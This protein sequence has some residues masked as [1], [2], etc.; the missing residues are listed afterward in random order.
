VRIV[1]ISDTHLTAAGGA[2][3]RNLERIAAFV[4][5]ALRPDLIVHTGDAVAIDPDSAADRAFALAAHAAFDAPVR[6]VPGN[7]DVGEPGPAPREGLAITSARV[8][9]QREAFGADRF[10]EHAG[11]WGQVGVDSRLFG[12]GLPEEAEQWDWLAATLAGAGRHRSGVMPFLHQPLWEPWPRPSE[13]VAPSVPD[14][15]RERLLA[16]DGAERIRAGANGHLHVYRR[17]P[18]R[19]LL[20]VSGP[21]TGFVGDDDPTRFDQLG[22]V[23]W[24]LEAGTASAR[25]RAPADLEERHPGEIPELVAGIDAL[26]RRP[27][28]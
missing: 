14:A 12:S 17:R 7:H 9:A 26:R 4:K 11:G 24:V 15:A 5:R 27:A 22:V 10:A 3:A 28:A 1:Q 13:G 2:P 6:F 18:D 16:L 8:A 21:A 23:E 19:G 25:F 20:E